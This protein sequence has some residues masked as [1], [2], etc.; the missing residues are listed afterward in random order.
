MSTILAPRTLVSAACATACAA[1]LALSAG[2]AM[3]QTKPLKIGIVTFM[4]GAAAGPFGVPA[5]NAAE[6]TAEQLNAGK[7]PA[8]YA[9]KGFGR[10]AAGTGLHRR[11]WRHQQAGQRVPQT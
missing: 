4:S 7:V 10:C 6:L 1:M 5:K 11:S 3:A 2:S 8:P 9:T